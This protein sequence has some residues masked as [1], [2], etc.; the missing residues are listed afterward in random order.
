M[1]TTYDMLL[2]IVELHSK[3]NLQEAEVLCRQILEKEPDNADANH[4]MGIIAYEAGR[5]DIAREYLEKAI[6]LNPGNP[7]CY[8]N[9]GNIVHG[10]GKYEESMEWYEKAIQMNYTDKRKAYNN[11]GVALTRLGRLKDAAEAFKKSIDLDPLYHEAH[12]NIGETYKFMGEYDRALESYEQA[13]RLFPEFVPARWNR[14]M[15][16]LLKGDFEKG[17]A[18]YEWRWQRPNTPKRKIDAGMPWD[19]GPLYG[20]T[21]FVYEEQGMGD[22]LQFIRYLPLLK[23]LGG[24]VIFEVLTPM[25]RLLESFKGFD[26]LWVAIRNVDTRPTDRFDYHIPLMSLPRIFNT[27]TDSIP[28]DIPYLTADPHLVRIWRKRM[29]SKPGFRIGVVF[30]GHPEHA[31]DVSRSAFLSSFLPLKELKG[32]QIISLQKEKYEKWTD[33]N[34]AEFFDQDFGEEISDFADTAAII[35]NL[36]LVISIDTAVVHLA[37]A[38][39]KQVW[40]LLPFSPDFRW[41]IGREDTPWYPTMKL[42]RQPEPGDWGS[43]FEKVKHCLEK[44]LKQ[45]G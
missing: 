29:E 23:A 24:H 3:R 17:W 27:R 13:V 37:G 2:Q 30:A 35:E 14:S 1:T 16:Y 18:E 43:I 39:G 28:A 8:L 44:R 21:L 34:P 38:L 42:F 36:D 31:N 10:E 5:L 40:T 9:L 4:F 22:T 41:M 7:S 19:G 20:K 15:L 32:V 45:D 12:N 26:R 11:L 33:I 6:C 25:I